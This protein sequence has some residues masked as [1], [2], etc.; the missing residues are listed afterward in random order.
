MTVCRR[1]RL[2]VAE[3]TRHAKGVLQG[4]AWVPDCFFAAGQ[5]KWQK[6]RRMGVDREKERVMLSTDGAAPGDDALERWVRSNLGC[7]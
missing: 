4:A 1:S 3:G 7:W 5:Q 6:L 2:S